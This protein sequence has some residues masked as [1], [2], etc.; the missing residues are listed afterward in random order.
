M[1][2]NLLGTI[3]SR[4]YS[5]ASWAKIRWYLISRFSQQRA[6]SSAAQTNPSSLLCMQKNHA[7][8]QHCSGLLIKCFVWLCS[9][10]WAFT[11]SDRRTDRSVR[12]VCPTSR[13]KRLHVPIVRPT[14]R[15]DPSYVRLSVRPV[16]MSIKS[17]WPVS[18][19]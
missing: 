2:T 10:Y 6:T 16:M 14:G 17:M 11:R 13:M 4:P 19:L 8:H 7:F 12:L 9:V 3:S 15:S 1:F 5:N 18:W